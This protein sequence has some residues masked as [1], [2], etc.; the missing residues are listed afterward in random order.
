MVQY[1]VSSC[2]NFEIDSLANGEP[3]QIGQNWR[4]VA[5]P[6]LLCN[7]SSKGFNITLPSSRPGI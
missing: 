4:D 5:V 1:L 2:S 7:K 6:T 3:V